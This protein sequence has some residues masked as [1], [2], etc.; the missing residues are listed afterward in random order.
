MAR[1]RK[2]VCHIVRKSK[3]LKKLY[4]DVGGTY[5]RSELVGEGSSIAA[6]VSSVEVG[7]MSYIDAMLHTHSDVDFIGISYAGQVENGSILSAPNIHIDCYEIARTVRS[8]YGI[9]LAIDNDLNCA[10]RAEAEYWNTRNIAALSVGTGIGAAVIDRGKL[11]R[12]SRNMAFEIGHIPYQDSPLLCGCGRSNCIELYASGSGLSKWME[13]E[14]IDGVIDLER[15]KRGTSPVEQRIAERF[16]E[17]LLFAAG[18]L[19]TLANPE[20]LVL[21]GGI[22]RHNPYLLAYLRENLNR[23]APPFAGERLRIERS[24]LENPSLDGA[25]RLER[26]DG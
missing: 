14:G 22:I 1:E 19:V 20:V 11:V 3:L 13:H 26:D 6:T 8:R 12:G 10:V 9:A 15:F 23:Y 17:A 18:V 4:I 2:S 21:G 7:L 25:K 5:I 16:E 24:V